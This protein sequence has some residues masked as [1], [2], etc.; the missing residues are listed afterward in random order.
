MKV[1]QGRSFLFILTIKLSRTTST[2][3]PRRELSID[4]VTGESIFNNKQI[5]LSSCFTFEPETSIGQQG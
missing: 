5:T 1:K 3:G 2:K 4:V